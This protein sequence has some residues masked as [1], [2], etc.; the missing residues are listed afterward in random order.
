MTEKADYLPGWATGI[1][2]RLGLLSKEEPPA[3]DK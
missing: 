1:A 3:S 2:R